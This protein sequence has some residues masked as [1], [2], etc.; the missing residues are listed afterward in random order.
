MVSVSVDKDTCIGCGACVSMCPGVFAIEDHKSVVKK[1]DCDGCDCKA[2][3]E[4]CPV[5]AIKVKE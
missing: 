2:V 4:A 1:N 3:A 5:G